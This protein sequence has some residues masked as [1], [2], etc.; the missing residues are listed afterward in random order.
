MSCLRGV[1]RRLRG[2][3]L[4]L[5]L[6]TNS[7]SPNALSEG[8]MKHQVTIMF[9]VM[10]TVLAMLCLT[11]TQVQGANWPRLRG[12]SG[13]GTVETAGLAVEFGPHKSVV[14]KTDLPPGKSSPILTGNRIVVT[15]SEGDRLLTIC[16]SQATGEIL[17]QREIIPKREEK[18]NR[19]NGP[20]APTPAT[21]GEN[22]YVFF[23]DFGLAAYDLDGKI[24]WEVPL[25]PFRSEHGMVSSPVLADGKVFVVAD[26]MNDSFAAAFDTATGKTLWK[27]DRPNTLGGY[28][29]PVVYQPEAGPAELIVPGPFELVSYDANT[30][31]KL[32]WMTRLAHQPKSFPIIHGD[33]LYVNVL[34]LLGTHWPSYDKMLERFDQNADGA[35]AQDELGKSGWVRRSFTGFDLNRNDLL[36][37]EEWSKLLDAESALWAV[38]L[39]GRGDVTDTHVLW[40]HKKSL[41]NV[42]APVI[43]ND[44]LYLVRNGGILTALD[45]RTGQVLKRGRLR[46]AIDNYYASPV[47]ADDKLYVA[48]ET[49][50]VT[51]VRAGKQWQILAVSDFSEDIYATPALVEGRIYLR[52]M[53][54]LYCFQEAALVTSAREGDVGR[55]STVLAEANLTPTVLTTALGAAERAN[56]L[57]IAALLRE[58]GATPEVR[59]ESDAWKIPVEILRS[60]AGEYQSERGWKMNFIFEEGLFLLQNNRG[61]QVPEPINQ[62][63]FRLPGR[64][65]RTVE[66]H[67]EDG[68]VTSITSTWRDQASTLKRVAEQ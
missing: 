59:E 19:L 36:D 38:R 32:W 13:A 47:A 67:V 23:A 53:K 12:P 63:T 21:D 56:N 43:Y 7:D 6:T 31:E 60:Y 29:T 46:G 61:D 11:G 28:A 68:K 5:V 8:K 66:F 48:S 42:P 62:T 65:P 45:P 51:V 30:G 44:V 58:A 17:W 9:T 26:L 22:V 14:W 15:A 18:R 39:G 24:L 55:V 52:T 49:G 37:E 57:E 3:T 16:L 41:P 1:G 25:G 54:A 34:G 64:V 27:V 10:F 4:S 50:K 33:T 2:E 35:I 20:A 40:N